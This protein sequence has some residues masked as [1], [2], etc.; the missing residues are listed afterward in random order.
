MFRWWI[1]GI[2]AAAIGSS[3]YYRRRARVEGGTI[4]R[5]EEGPL[6]IT[7]RLLVTLPLLAALLAYLINPAWMSWSELRMPTWLRWAGVVLGLFALASVHWVLSSLGK[8]VSETVLTKADHQLVMEG[9][10]R[11]VRHP[12]YTT[13]LALLLAVGLMSAN[14]VLLGFP[15]LAVVFILAVIVPREEAALK[16]RFGDDYQRYSERTGRLLPR[17]GKPPAKPTHSEVP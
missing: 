4:T 3:A 17:G 16:D 7:L 12:L 14:A 10:Y 15:V 1:L 2:L 8:N 6:L 13:G 11:W 5:G 9:P